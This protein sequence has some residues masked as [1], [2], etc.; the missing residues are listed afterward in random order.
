MIKYA[1]GKIQ[2]VNAKELQDSACEC[3]ASVNA[4]YRKLLGAGANN[5]RGVKG[6]AAQA[7]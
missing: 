2:I 1:R 6:S 7:G 3:Y 5:T 4:H